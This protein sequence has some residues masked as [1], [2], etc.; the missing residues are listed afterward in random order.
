[1]PTPLTFSQAET[2]LAVLGSD[3]S[4]ISAA[5]AALPAT[6]LEADLPN[7]VAIVSSLNTAATTLSNTVAN[8]TSAIARTRI[9]Q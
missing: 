7:I 4:N 8:I 9:N 2:D 5:I 1:M 3:L 6:P